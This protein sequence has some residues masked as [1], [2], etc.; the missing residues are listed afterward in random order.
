M[1]PQLRKI[2]LVLPVLQMMIN[3]IVEFD[4]YFVYV[5]DKVFKKLHWPMELLKYPGF[6]LGYRNYKLDLQSPILWCA[7]MGA[8]SLAA[9]SFFHART[10]HIEINAH[11]V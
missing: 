10:N 2:F 5:K 6:R 11:F 9:N 8:E 4:S 3:T 1:F 7:N